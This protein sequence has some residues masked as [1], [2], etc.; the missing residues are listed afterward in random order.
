[1]VFCR[2]KNFQFDRVTSKKK[3]DAKRYLREI[4]LKDWSPQAAAQPAAYVL[5][6]KKQ[7]R[8]VN[9]MSLVGT[10]LE[11]DMDLEDSGDS[12]SEL[13]QAFAGDGILELQ[14]VIELSE[15]DC[16]LQLPQLNHVTEKGN[17]VDIV[18]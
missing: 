1:M 16:Y 13:D 11:M 3:A 8:K 18:S 15:V 10:M 12:S 9:G 2:F 5:D 4:Y 14:G 6:V 7:R 17:D